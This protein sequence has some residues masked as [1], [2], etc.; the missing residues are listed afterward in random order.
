MCDVSGK[1]P[2]TTQS[3]FDSRERASEIQNSFVKGYEIKEYEEFKRIST[4]VLGQIK[5]ITLLYNCS[6]K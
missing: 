5:E 3:K 1:Q 6:H 4:E 2:I